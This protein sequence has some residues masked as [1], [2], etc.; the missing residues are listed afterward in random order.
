MLTIDFLLFGYIGI[1][2]FAIQMLWI[3]FWAAGVINGV[4][5]YWGY[6]NF[7][8]SDASSNIMPIGILIGG[9]EFHNNHHA[10]ASSA[11]LANKWWEFDIGWFYIRCMELLR[12]ADVRK[13]APQVT[14]EKGKITV[15]IETVRA[16]V[17]NRVHVMKLY[18]RDVIKPVIRQESRKANIYFRKSIRRAR[19]FMIR[20]DVKIDVKAK[21][22][23]NE[24]T[25]HSQ[26]LATVYKFKQQLKELWLRTYQNQEKRVA[27]LQEWCN[28]AEQ[29]GIKVLQ[30]FARSIRG[31]TLQTA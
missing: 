27:S 20:E 31:Y 3:P 8:T 13:T 24:V 25:E 4:G 23:L 21:Q 29:T 15:D 19:R 9:E 18:G 26:A 14:L 7:E 17:R 5:H 30:D 2:I 10:Y 6:R 16:V 28:Q 1:T 12:L 22:L 11:R